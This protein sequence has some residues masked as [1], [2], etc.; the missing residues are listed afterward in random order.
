VTGHDAEIR[1]LAARVRERVQQ[2]R[3]EAFRDAGA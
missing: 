2:A 1:E 3:D